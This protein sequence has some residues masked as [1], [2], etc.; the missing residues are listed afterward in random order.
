MDIMKS[1]TR[2]FLRMLG[3]E[4]AKLAIERDEL[5]E[6]VV[7]ASLKERGKQVTEVAKKSAEGSSGHLLNS[8]SLHFPLSLIQEPIASHTLNSG[9]AWRLALD[10][11]GRWL[12]STNNSGLGVITMHDLKSDSREPVRTFN[13]YQIYNVRGIALEGGGGKE[14][15]AIFVCGDHMVH[16]YS[17]EGSF[18]QTFGTCYPGSDTSHCHDPNG[19]SVYGDRLYVCDSLNERILVLTI[20]LEYVC[21]IDNKRCED[22]ATSL[23]HVDLDMD[24]GLELL[25]EQKQEQKRQEKQQQ[26]QEEKQQQQEEQQE[27]QQQ[28]EEKQQQQEEKQQQQQEKQHP[29]LQQQQHQQHIAA[30]SLD[31]LCSESVCPLHPY[32]KHPE[33]LLFDSMGNLHVVDSGKAAIAVFDSTLHLLHYIKLPVDQLPFPVSM[34]LLDG[35]Y[36]IADYHQGYVIVANMVGTVLHQFVVQS[37]ENDMEGF[38][39]VDSREQQYPL[40]LEVDAAGLIYVSNTCSDQ[41]WVY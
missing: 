4:S 3:H 1:I 41:I 20:D 21:S 24:D 10:S 22:S 15:G 40:G 8:V 5:C 25:D 11:S 6:Y 9:Y 27:K 38:L 32:L 19:M 34:R 18:L 29:G 12:Y 36:Y 16:K 26:Q 2:G 14:G 23:G 30:T 37:Q 28:Q 7:L 13:C 35:H 31:C 33:D 39:L 17:Q